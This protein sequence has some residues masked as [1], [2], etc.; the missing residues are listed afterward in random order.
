MISTASKNREP[1][2]KPYLRVTALNTGKVKIRT[3]LSAGATGGGT[4]AKPDEHRRA[5]EDD[6]VG[7]LSNISLFFQGVLRSHRS[8]TTSNHD[9]LVVASPVGNARQVGTFLRLLRGQE[10]SKAA[11]K[12]RTTELVVEAGTADGCLQHDVQAAGVVARPANVSLPGGVVVGDEE[13]RDPEAAQASLCRGSS[14]N[15]SLVSDLS[16]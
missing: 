7:A 12:S 10:S 13:V 4:T 5:P 15:R 1:C 14:S 9:G 11:C 3:A 8:E 6:D 16:A 2:K